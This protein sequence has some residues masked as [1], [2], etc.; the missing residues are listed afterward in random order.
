MYQGP[1]T[2]SRART[3]QTAE[4]RGRSIVIPEQWEEESPQFG[5]VQD[6]ENETSDPQSAQAV[7]EIDPAEPNRSASGSPPFNSVTRPYSAPSW[8]DNMTEGGPR[9]VFTGQPGTMTFRSFRM[10]LEAELFNIRQRLSAVDPTDLAAVA[11]R[12]YQEFMQLP[13]FLGD[14][15][16]ERY[17]QDRD[18]ILAA[19]QITTDPVAAASLATARQL[20]QT[21]RAG[22]SNPPTAQYF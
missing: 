20:E 18:K 16:L 7:N 1:Q 10:K 15:A 12:E 6:V 13:R 2:R 17:E 9:F 19:T 4:V 5:N 22:R 14:L 11:D 3:T 21:V 8:E